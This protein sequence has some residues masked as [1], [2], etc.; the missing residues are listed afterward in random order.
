[1]TI[2][3]RVR[4]FFSPRPKPS[5]STLTA[6][7]SQKEHTSE[8]ACQDAT[9]DIDSYSLIHK[10]G[11]QCPSGWTCVP[12]IF[13]SKDGSKCDGCL[14]PAY[15]ESFSIDYLMPGERVSLMVVPKE[16]KNDNHNQSQV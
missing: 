16:G 12:G 1:M 8:Q 7:F 3:D 15:S 4:T 10:R 6:S 11:D 13:I 2:W 9:A 5:I 14:N